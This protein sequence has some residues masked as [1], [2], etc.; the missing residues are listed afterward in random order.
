[1]V[2]VSLAKRPGRC[3][4]LRLYATHGVELCLKIFGD[5]FSA[6]FRAKSGFL[7][8]AKRRHFSREHTGVRANDTVLQSLSDAHDPTDITG[9]KI[10]GEAIFGVIS[11]LDCLVFRLEGLDCRDRS[12]NFL[13]GDPHILGDAGD[14]GWAAGYDVR[15]FGPGIIDEFDH[16][17]HRRRADERTDGDAFCKAIPDAEG[18]NCRLKLARKLALDAALDEN[19]IG[20]DASLAAISE[21]GGH[22]VDDSSVDIGI[23]END[24]RGI[25]AKFQ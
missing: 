4:S 24:K 7:P 18:L 17:T 10:R 13:F 25:A 8:A 9:C 16:L 19:S 5:T 6:A 23:I 21:L 1:M 20:A 15:A 11:A 14:E 2:G 22:A 3:K 12:E